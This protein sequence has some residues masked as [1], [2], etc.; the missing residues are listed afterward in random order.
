MVS[1]IA[2]SYI[3]TATLLARQSATGTDTD[4][5]SRSKNTPAAQTASQTI[6]D[7][8]TLSPQA[9]AAL[10]AAKSNS[11]DYFS[12]FLPTRDGDDEPATALALAITNPGAESF[13]E[14]KTLEEVATA[15]RASM[16]VK[17]TQMEEDGE[18]YAYNSF[19]G[20]DQNTLMADFDRRALYAVSS[21][22]GGLFTQKEQEAA[23]YIMHQQR[24]LAMGAYHGPTSQ[25]E[26][27]TDPFGDDHA[28]RYKAGTQWLDNVSDDEKSSIAWASQRAGTQASYEAQMLRQGDIPEN[29]DSKN[30]LVKLLSQALHAK[31]E[32]FERL[33]I[34]G[35]NNATADD[36]KD[37]P[38]LEGFEGR[39]EAVIKEA[40]D[41]YQS[42]E[43]EI[44]I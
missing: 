9:I 4:D 11:A 44:L 12:Q 27:F 43:I 29:L 7:I 18:P 38:W 25:I 14:G 20:R 5:A 35:A 22:E 19:E 28:A 36:L 37:E 6:T 16:D 31:L 23:T 24:V 13:S 42:A 8:I 1:A 2:A 3:N 21:N 33:H 41:F 32:N 15:A 30:P 34:V 26:K 10:E 39:L 17:Y 40:Q